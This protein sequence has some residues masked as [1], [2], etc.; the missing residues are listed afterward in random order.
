MNESLHVAAT[1]NAMKFQSFE[2]NFAKPVKIKNIRNSSNLNLQ[3]DPRLIKLASKKLLLNNVFPHLNQNFK[4]DS[5]SIDMI[6]KLGFSKGFLEEIP[7]LEDQWD[8]P[9]D[10]RSECVGPI[11][12]IPTFVDSAKLGRL[13]KQ[14]SEMNII[15]SVRGFEEIK[16][17]LSRKSSP[18][19]VNEKQDSSD[20]PKNNLNKEW[21]NS[22]HNDSQEEIK[23]QVYANLPQPPIRR[24]SRAFSQ[25]QMGS[26]Q[27]FKV[28]HARQITM[29]IWGSQGGVYSSELE[30]ERVE[31]IANHLNLNKS[32][33]NSHHYS[34]ISGFS[35]SIPMNNRDLSNKISSF[36]S[37]VCDWASILI[38]DDQIINRL[39]LNEFGKKFKIK[40]DEAENGKIAVQKYQNT[41]KKRWCKGYKLILMD[42]NMPV[43]NG[44]KAAM[45]ILEI[46]T[47]YPKP[48]IIAVT[49]FTSED[50]RQKWFKVGMADVKHKPISSDT[51]QEILMKMDGFNK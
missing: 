15:N 36:Y 26:N 50:E 18:N 42:I 7:E 3:S 45:K 48:I 6:S 20:T 8:I 35:K 11:P 23:D 2:H 49:G 25:F 41:L 47:P 10:I 4:I 13:I 30:L 21:D 24:N 19:I 44:I 40:S 33:E 17:P 9:S 5:E 51:Y 38:V 22:S 1:Q 12:L 43:M 34:K 27:H 16:I 46:E 29:K 39:I 32:N 28:K 14:K 37:P 31:L